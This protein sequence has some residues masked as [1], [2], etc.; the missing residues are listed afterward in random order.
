MSRSKLLD[1][2]PSLLLSRKCNISTR[3]SYKDPHRHK[4]ISYILNIRNQP[5]TRTQHKTFLVPFF[6]LVY[7]FQQIRKN[8]KKS[9][10]IRSIGRGYLCKHYIKK[11]V[12]V[13]RKQK[14]NYS[15]NR[16]IAKSPKQ[17][18]IKKK[19]KVTMFDEA[20]RKRNEPT[21]R[22]TQPIK[23]FFFF[24]LE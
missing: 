21:N 23:F 16:Q 2:L 4:H 19:K 15:T 22:P 18:N 9:Q 12:G 13:Q 8:R 24:F 3:Q 6:L 10:K 1:T 7:S 17:Q 5:Q 14:N 20:I 11:A